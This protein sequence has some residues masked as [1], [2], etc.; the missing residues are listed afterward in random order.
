MILLLLSMLLQYFT[1]FTKTLS[2]DQM[3]MAWIMHNSVGKQNLLTEKKF[4][5]EFKAVLLARF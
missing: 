3:R 2:F 5:R 4:G 1:Y